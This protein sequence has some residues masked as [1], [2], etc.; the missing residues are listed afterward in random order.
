MACQLH[1]PNNFTFGQSKKAIGQ[2]S[3]I[4]PCIA[5]LWWTIVRL[6]VSDHDGRRHN[7]EMEPQ[8]RTV[9]PLHQWRR[10]TTSGPEEDHSRSRRS[11]GWAE[12][13]EKNI[14]IGPMESTFLLTSLLIGPLRTTGCLKKPKPI[15]ATRWISL[16]LRNLRPNRLRHVRTSVNFAFSFTNSGRPQAD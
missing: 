5:T 10:T 2:E 13:R 16:G 9:S 3:P 15:R 4:G 8:E 11:N 7:S 6:V 14:G 1:I 12:C